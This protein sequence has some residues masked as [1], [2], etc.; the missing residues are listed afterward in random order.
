M[1]SEAMQDLARE[2][3]RLWPVDWRS[4]ETCVY[5]TVLGL[6][7]VTEGKDWKVYTRHLPSEGKDLHQQLLTVRA[8]VIQQ[9]TSIPDV[10]RPAE[11]HEIVNKLLNA[12]GWVSSGGGYDAW[13]RGA[14]RIVL[15]PQNHLTLW[16][17]Y[18]A[19]LTVVEIGSDHSPGLVHKALVELFA[20]LPEY[21]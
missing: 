14:W 18:T 17:G 2:C 5:A 3:N 9:A 1:K 12:R 4:T 7:I 10:R 13:E 21:K 16:K 6:Y 8:C 15:S 11:L 20:L 19:A